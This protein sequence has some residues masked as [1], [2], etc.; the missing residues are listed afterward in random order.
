MENIIQRIE[1]AVNSWKLQVSVFVEP[2]ELCM[3]IDDHKE[4]HT[5]YNNINPTTM[6]INTIN[7]QNCIL[8]VKLITNINFSF[9]CREDSFRIAS[10]GGVRILNEA[11]LKF[12]DNSNHKINRDLKIVRV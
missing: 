4:L 11:L 10:K 2:T 9:I 7:I 5:Y 1:E 12:R 3:N 8:K 6:K